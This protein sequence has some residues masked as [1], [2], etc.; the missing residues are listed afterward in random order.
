MDL[1][2]AI[3][4]DADQIVRVDLVDL[5]LHGAS[6]GYTLVDYDNEDLEG[7]RADERPNL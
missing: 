2:K 1:Q 7:I 5:D 6:Y 3:F 4:V